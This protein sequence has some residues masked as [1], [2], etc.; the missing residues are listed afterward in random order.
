MGLCEIG[1][2]YI[3]VLDVVDLRTAEIL[4]ERAG[5][6]SIFFDFSHFKKSAKLL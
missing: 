3:P 6:I 2:P 5:P 1:V 4:V